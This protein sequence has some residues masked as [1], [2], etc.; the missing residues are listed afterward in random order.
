M[1]TADQLKALLK[2]YADGDDDRFLA[3]SMQVASHAAQKGQGKL[4]Q[5]LRALI[6]QA[7][8]RQD[9]WKTQNP[10]PIARASG[11]LAGLL[12]ASFPKV[13]LSEMVLSPP[14]EEQL[15]QIILE[16]RQQQKLRAHGLSARRKLLLVGPPGSGKTMT[17]SALAGELGIPLLAVQLHAVIT[18]F[19]GETAAKLHFIFEAM[20]RTRGVY[21]FDEFDA[22]G[23]SRDQSNDIGEMRRVLNSFLQ[24]LEQDDSDSITIAATNHKGKLD[25]ALF[26]RFDDV[27]RYE[28]PSPEL[29][30]KLIKNRLGLFGVDSL[31]WEEILSA[32][33]GLSYAELSRACDDA[34]RKAIL[35]NRAE[36]STDS[37]VSSIRDRRVIN[38]L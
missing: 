10:V 14:T 37:L 9:S 33:E 32:A 22:I 12:S 5:E 11:E 34:A 30:T 36:V 38:E 20:Q 23:A 1:A 27:V 13:H 7:R 19:M 17:A 28:L 4:A 21:L 16:Y 8:L 31:K 24:F 25:S 18:K 26:R 15:S 2:S 35:S 29:A 3:I 6:D